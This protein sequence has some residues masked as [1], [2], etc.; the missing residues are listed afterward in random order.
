METVPEKAQIKLSKLKT[1][2]KNTEELIKSNSDAVEKKLPIVKEKTEALR[3]QHK[4]LDAEL[5]KHIIV[6][7][8]IAGN[9]IFIN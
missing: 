3:E 7:D 4:I 9:V 1:D 5:S 8:E 2:L 6:E